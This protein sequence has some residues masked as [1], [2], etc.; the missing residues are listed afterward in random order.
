MY[1]RPIYIDKPRS[2]S[3]KGAIGSADTPYT[4]TP[5]RSPVTEIAISPKTARN[6]DTAGQVSSFSRKIHNFTRLAGRNLGIYF[7]FKNARISPD[8]RSP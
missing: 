1:T 3:T 6:T 5:P 4:I 7:L 2:L 8:K